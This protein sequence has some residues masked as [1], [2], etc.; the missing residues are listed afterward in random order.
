VSEQE[1]KQKAHRLLEE[2]FGQGKLEDV[3]EVLNPD[4]VC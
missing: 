2:G 3:D 1:N 4:F